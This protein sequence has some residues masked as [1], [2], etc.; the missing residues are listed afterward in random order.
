[1]QSAT[2]SK[3]ELLHQIARA[4][5]IDGL[6]AKK[7]DAIPYDDQV[8]LRA[9]LRPGGSDNPLRGKQNLREQWFAPLPSLLGKV[10]FIDSYVNDDSTAVAA[11]F[12]C[13]ILNPACTLRVIDRFRVNDEGK[14]IEQENFFD[15]RDV[16]NPGSKG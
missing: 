6:A 11:E 2:I 12:L 16:T 15:P 10:K 1:M 7:F 5:V 3:T 4:Y 9:P 8:V 13:E 14:I